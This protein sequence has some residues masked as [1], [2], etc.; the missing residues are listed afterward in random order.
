VDPTVD[1]NWG[2]GSPDALIQVDDFCSRWSGQ[3]Q[4]LDTD[5]Y[6][7]YVNA[8]DGVRLWVNGQ[9][10][11]DS[12]ILSGNG[13]RSG[14]IALTANQK[15]LIVM[16]HYEHQVTSQAHL[17]WTTTNGVNQGVSYEVIPATQLYPNAS[18]IEPTVT[19]TPGN[20]SVNAPVTLTAGVTTNTAAEISSVQFFT[21][22]VLLASAPTTTPYTY[23]W[24]P[25]AAGTYNVFAQVQYDKS[26]LVYSS[27]N[28]LVVSLAPPPSSVTISN[29]T[30]TTITYG[31]GGG[32]LF[33]LMTTNALSGNSMPHDGWQ[34]LATNFTTGGSFSITPGTGPAFYYIKSE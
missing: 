30:A 8:D 4:A 33:V 18:F 26:T 9:N 7:F 20:G 16:E 1:F 31:G 27:T 10:L 5:N 15:Y 13:Q 2:S 25:P 29:I 12:W 11:V 28:A 19:L 24:T 22:N 23:A 6:T 21:N 3:V 14:T 32:A 17:R 34:R